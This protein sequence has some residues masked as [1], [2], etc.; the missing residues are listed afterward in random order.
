MRRRGALE[1]PLAIDPGLVP[2]PRLPA[3]V[4][5]SGVSR[6]RTIPRL[7]LGRRLPA[8][9]GLRDNDRTHARSCCN[10]ELRHSPSV[11]LAA[12]HVPAPPPRRSPATD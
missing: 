9:T 7:P 10:S 4:V 1:R 6:R 12:P 3:V 11:A 5:L 8:H 2:N